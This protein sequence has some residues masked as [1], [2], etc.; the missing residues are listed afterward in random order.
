MEAVVQRYVVEVE[1]TTTRTFEVDAT[2]F[3]QAKERYLD[4]GTVVHSEGHPEAV[5]SVVIKPIL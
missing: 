1:Q 2:S 3:E 5:K 4:E